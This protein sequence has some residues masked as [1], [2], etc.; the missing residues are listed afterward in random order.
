MEV[1]P[2][3]N[4]GAPRDCRAGQGHLSSAVALKTNVSSGGDN[5]Q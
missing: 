3:Q 1:T 4:G 5:G 2:A